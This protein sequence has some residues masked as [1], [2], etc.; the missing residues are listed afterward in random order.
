MTALRTS[1][2]ETFL[3]DPDPRRPV[4]LIYGPDLGLV[5]E[6]ADAVV[7]AVAPGADPFAVVPLEGDAI[8]SDPGR[9]IDEARTIGLFGGKRVI[10]VRA[11]GKS[12]NDALETLLENP[13]TDAIVVIEAGELSLR[14]DCRLR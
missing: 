3:A 1:E 4:I 8:A 12:F 2:V 11:G 10:R 6:R 13:P 14:H 7:E 9:L 5:R